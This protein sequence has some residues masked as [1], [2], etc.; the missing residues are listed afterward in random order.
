MAMQQ[1]KRQPKM[2]GSEKNEKKKIAHTQQIPNTVIK[3]NPAKIT[4]STLAK[5]FYG[6]C[7]EWCEQRNTN[8][9]DG[10]KIT[11]NKCNK[12]KANVKICTL[13]K[14]YTNI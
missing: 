9:E 7:T 2:A 3:R 11:L 1:Y 14:I 13:T 4:N 10:K 6:R 8:G 5:Q 12:I